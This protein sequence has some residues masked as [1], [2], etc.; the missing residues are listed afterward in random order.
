MRGGRHEC[1]AG[2]LLAAQSC[3]HT[4]EGA[5][6]LAYLVAAAILRQR[7]GL[8]PAALELAGG[9]AQPLQA[10][11]QRGRQADAEQQRDQQPGTCG[12]EERGAHDPYGGGDVV[13][14][15]GEH[16]ERSGGRRS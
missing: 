6:Q 10:A 5:G 1:A 11:Q 13:Q 7:L 16:H 9:V 4:G 8:R 14:A 12:L 2:G 3:L 15:L